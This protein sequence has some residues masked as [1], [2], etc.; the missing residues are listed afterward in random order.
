MIEGNPMSQSQEVFLWQKRK[1]KLIVLVLTKDCHR[2]M[3][4]VRLEADR[5]ITIEDGH[6]INDERRR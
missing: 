6:I 5:I 4:E 2:M 1:I 3:A